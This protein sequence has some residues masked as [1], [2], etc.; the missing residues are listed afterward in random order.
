[1]YYLM[2][3]KELLKIEKMYFHLLQKLQLLK[4]NNH[5]NIIIII[6]KRIVRNLHKLRKVR[7]RMLGKMVGYFWSI[8][9]LWILIDWLNFNGLLIYIYLYICFYT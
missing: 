5:N 6:I 8:R 2:L 4:C 3:V 7:N 1:M 9:N